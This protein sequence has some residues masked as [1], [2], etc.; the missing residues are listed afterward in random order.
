VD[1]RTT[2]IFGRKPPVPTRLS[3]S[4]RAQPPRPSIA[5]TASRS[6]L[7]AA[8]VVVLAACGG[9]STTGAGRLAAAHSAYERGAFEDAQREA[10]A[11]ERSSSGVARDEATYLA[12]LSAARL[13]RLSDAEASFR[14]TMTSTDRDLAERARRS[15]ETLLRHEGREREIA[16]LAGSGRAPIDAA[17]AA[18]QRGTG[19]TVQVGAY[20]VEANARRRAGEVRDLAL[21]RGLPAP[22]IVAIRSSDGRTLYAVRIG[23]FPD[24]RRAG[25]AREALGHPEWAVEMVGG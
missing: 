9:A 24:R 21:R 3:G 15:L 18:P 2:P 8:L 5:Q 19:F 23:R 16:S 7:V 22:E 11:A 6:A 12:G 4:L 1:E 25:E 10:V 20:A 14:S 13:G 17:T